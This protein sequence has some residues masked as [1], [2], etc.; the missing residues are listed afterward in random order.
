MCFSSSSHTCSAG[1]RP[2]DCGG[3]W[4]MPEA[5]VLLLKSLAFEAG[6]GLHY[7]FESAIRV[8]VQNC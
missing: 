6:G 2:G 4:K 1:L 7:H 8:Q 3:Q 5:C